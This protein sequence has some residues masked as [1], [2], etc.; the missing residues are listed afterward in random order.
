MLTV[1]GVAWSIGSMGQHG[2]HDYLMQGW[3]SDNSTQAVQCSYF[4]LNRCYNNFDGVLAA[5][6]GD[7]DFHASCANC[8]AVAAT[9][10][11]MR[12]T[13]LNK[14]QQNVTAEVNLSRC[15]PGE[16]N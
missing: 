4:W 5:A 13:C 6:D 3:C 1:P 8:V 9:P 2:K 14:R 12:C 16:Q 11:S 10:G 15:P 7:G